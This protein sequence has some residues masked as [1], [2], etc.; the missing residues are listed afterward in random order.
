MLRFI[1]R[2]LYSLGVI[3]DPLDAFK[4]I[5][6][7]ADAVGVEHLDVVEVGVGR[8]AGGIGRARPNRSVTMPAATEATW[9]PWP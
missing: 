9:V 1:T 5:A 2:M 6:Q 8:D 7:R 3:D 4:R